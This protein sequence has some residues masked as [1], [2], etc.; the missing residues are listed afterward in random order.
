M[1]ELD[2]LIIAKYAAKQLNTDDLL[3]FADRKLNEGETSD[4]LIELLY[5]KK[6]EWNEIYPCFESAISEIGEGI[7][8]PDEAI[9]MILRYHISIIANQENNPFKQFKLLLNDIEWFP[10]YEKTTKYVGDAIGIH[11]LYGLY[12]SPDDL[13]KENFDENIKIIET[14]MIQE[15]KKWL[16]VYMKEH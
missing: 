6:R 4:H 7:P 14:K 13:G 9:W 1:N 11:Y 2:K 15:S 3:D 16:T 8:T 12:Y 5:Y 10:Y